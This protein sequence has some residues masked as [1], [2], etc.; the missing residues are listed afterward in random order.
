MYSFSGGAADKWDSARFLAVFNASAESRSQAFS[1]PAHLR[2]TQAVGLHQKENKVSNLASLA[3]Q[4]FGSNNAPT[5]VFLHGGGVGGWMWQP[6]IKHLSEYHCL[7]P[8]QPEHGGSRAIA[9]FSIE[10]AAEK[11]TELIRDQAHEGKA[12]VVGLSEGAQITVQLLAT[13]PERVE[14]AIVSS[15]LIRPIV[16][17]G[18]ASS[19]SLL[20]WM[21]RLSIPPFINNDWWIRLNMKYSAGIPDEYYSDFKKSF[22][23]ITESEFVNLMITNQRFRLPTGLEKAN[24]P[25]LALAGKKEYS[26]MKQSVRDLVS[27]MPTAKGC[28]VNLG[29]NSSMAKEHNWALTAPELFAQ[30]LRAWIEDMLLPPAI[31]DL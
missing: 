23:E 2:L 13:A 20:A 10:L 14:K 18:W 22:Q 17:I 16:G 4:A 6:V 30:T 15:A 19:P 25:T 28:L 24:V 8:D 21:Y 5:I 1:R 11:V 12:Y 29:K 9:P 31:E 27:A 3:F 7:A 26:A